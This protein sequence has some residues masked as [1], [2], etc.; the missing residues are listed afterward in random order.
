M[1]NLSH[2][3]NRFIFILSIAMMLMQSCGSRKVDLETQQKTVSELQQ[4]DI[5]TNEKSIESS[6][7]IRISSADQFTFESADPQK[8]SFVISGA[9]TL[10]FKNAK[11]AINKTRSSEQ[12]EATKTTEKNTED[13]SGKKTESA[14]KK[15]TKKTESTSPSWGLNIGIIIGII[16]LI[17]LGYFHFQIKG[18][19]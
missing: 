9:D 13:H 2:P 16:V 15:K 6:Q 8:S 7:L 18:K 10:E 17:L 3:K 5:K 12:S 19:P 14:E 11:I 4:N 1:K